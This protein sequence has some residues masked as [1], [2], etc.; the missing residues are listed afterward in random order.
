MLLREPC[1]HLEK[2]FTQDMFDT[3]NPFA[4]I[5]VDSRCCDDGVISGSPKKSNK[6]RFRSTQ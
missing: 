3:A 5:S 6:H 2:L 1:G 4:M